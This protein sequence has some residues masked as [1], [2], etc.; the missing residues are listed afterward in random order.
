MENPD[1]KYAVN[2]DTIKTAVRDLDR[3]LLT[4]EAT[5][6]YARAS[7]LLREMGVVRPALQRTLDSLTDVP[8]DIA[9]KF[10][11]AAP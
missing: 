3:E 6:D 8:T 10:P 5:G 4:I 7:R 2:F 11:S 1:G 9:P